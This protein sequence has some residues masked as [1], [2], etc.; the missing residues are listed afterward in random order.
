MKN[1]VYIFSIILLLSVAESKEKSISKIIHTS[2][3]EVYGTAKFVPMTEKHQLSAQSPYAASKIGADQLAIS[4]YKS[5]N[6]PISILRPFNSFGPRQSS[7]A[8]IPTIVSQMLNS[9]YVKIGN[10]I[11]IH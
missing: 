3:S 11:H 1:L 2:T 10:Y 8:I 4:Y 6:L 7:R 9:K 5:Y